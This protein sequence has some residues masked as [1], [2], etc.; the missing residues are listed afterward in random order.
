MFQHLMSGWL[1]DYSYK[2]QPVDY[3]HNPTALRVN[4][5][6]LIYIFSN[7]NPCIVVVKYVTVSTSCQGLVS[8]FGKVRNI[9][10]A[11]HDA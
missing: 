2:C 7:I 3:S 1:L 4:N 5:V 11:T 10:L 9:A 8:Q 6:S